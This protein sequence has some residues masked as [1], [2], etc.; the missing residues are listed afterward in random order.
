MPTKRALIVDDSTTAQYRL[1]KML[2]PYDLD[3]DS[4]DSGEAAL[5]YL[6]THIPDV[7]F[8]D[9]LM[10]GMDGFRA[11]QIIKSHPETAMIPVIMYTSKS[12]DV[13]TGQARALGALDV[14]SKD[15][16][17]AADLSNVMRT[18]H[19]YRTDEN[20]EAKTEKPV[21]EIKV[22]R[23][24]AVDITEHA[25]ERRALNP[26][27]AEQARNLELRLSHMEHTLEDSRRFITERVVRELQGLKQ[28]IKQELSEITE[29]KHNQPNYENNQDSE[30]IAWAII[31]KLIIL[32]PLGLIAYYLVQVN[33]ALNDGQQQQQQLGKQLTAVITAQQ[34]A[35][36]AALQPENSTVDA[37]PATA[38]L[39][40]EVT[41]KNFGKQYLA[42]TAWVFNQTGALPF[43]QNDIDTKVVIRLYELLN[44]LI[45]NG[46]K[47]RVWIN[48]YI[49]NFCLTTDN[50][51]QS[52]LVSDTALMGN[53]MLSSEVYG[54][55]S[56]K[57]Q[58]AQNVEVALGGLDQ[59]LAKDLHIV[60]NALAEAE[61][62]PERK[63][64]L[65]AKTWNTAAQNHNRIE[66]SLEE[67]KSS[68]DE[69]TPAAAAPTNPIPAPA[70]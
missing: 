62:Y 40:R 56:L 12:G 23:R 9:H 29:H 58:Y 24:K 52:Q 32:I 45:H 69:V 33:S 61:D 25:I 17:N 68:L 44:R 21:E 64:T 57:E 3:T 18:I 27:N 41:G 6:A 35:E 11:L 59:K 39:A 42:D 49:G 1:K 65:S 7:I 26:N 37:T 54:L 46:F 55:D 28:N 20:P 63:P 50:V 38:P 8:M 67:A 13:Y 5:R 36:A 53:C 15:S 66:I 2:R 16:I 14:V 19:I 22:A 51:G 34:A 70:N 60:I 31:S 48:I 4:V 10:P 43:R 47:G 30:N